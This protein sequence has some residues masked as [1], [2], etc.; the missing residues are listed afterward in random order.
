[1]QKIS[2]NVF[3][4]TEY[5]GSNNGFIVTEKGIV[6]IDTP[7]L[8]HDALLWREQI[9]NYGEITYIINTEPHMDHYMGNFFFEGKVIAHEGTRKAMKLADLNSL[10]QRII[11]MAP[12]DSL[13]IEGYELKLPEITF[14]ERMILYLGSQE[15]QLLNL[16]GHT[17]FQVAVYLP[18]EKVVFTSDNVVNS[19]LPFMTQS[20]PDEWIKS[21]AV[22][23][24]LDF[25]IVVPGHGIVCDKSYISTMSLIINDWVSAVKEAIDKK[26]SLEEAV[27]SI[28]LPQRSPYPI[29][30]PVRAEEVRR[31][32]IE[33]L[34]RLY[35][36]NA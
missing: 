18:G 26:L 31:M 17:S 22:L 5:Q 4:E 1:M 35:Q 34:Y 36:F 20:S 10:K 28:K 6:L 33:Y 8:P 27:A 15:V 24:E 9:L 2:Q 29:M 19:A 3:V 23:S 13:L 16:P 30:N 12:E 14:Y 11:D 32:N 21:L 25:N 7:M